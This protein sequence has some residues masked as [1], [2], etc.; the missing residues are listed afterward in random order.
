[1]LYSI[2][3]GIHIPYLIEYNRERESTVYFTVLSLSLSLSP[4]SQLHQL[5]M[6]SWMDRS[7]SCWP[8]T[9]TMA[10]AWRTKPSFYLPRPRPPLPRPLPWLCYPT[11]DPIPST[12]LSSTPGPPVSLPSDLLCSLVI[13]TLMTRGSFGGGGKN[14]T[15]SFAN[16]F[17]S[18]RM[19]FF[20]PKWDHSM[21]NCYYDELFSCLCIIVNYR[22]STGY[23]QDGIF[24][25]PGK[26]GTQDVNDVQVQ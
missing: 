3:Y 18:Y 21:Y 20:R 16:S 9:P 15:P 12:P 6:N 14:V 26:I 24:S 5:S 23:G 17:T 25:L 1:M 8:L 2:K 13:K 19:S 11:A 7:T 4:P 10:L 22:G